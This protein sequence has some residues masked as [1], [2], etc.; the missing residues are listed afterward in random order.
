MGSS[1]LRQPGLRE[2][3]RRALQE[4]IARAAQKLFLLKGFEATTID[5][6]AA[7][8]G[9]SQRSFFR[10]FPTKEDI[11]LSKIDMM[12]SDMLDRLRNGPA[13]EPI[14]RSLRCIFD[15]VSENGEQAQVAEPIQRFVFTT[16]R[17]LAGYLQKLQKMQDE[18]VAILSEREAAIGRPFSV[19]D[20]APRALTS[21]AFGCLVAAQHSWLASGCSKPLGEFIDLAMATVAPTDRRFLP[22]G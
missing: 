13:E 17:L 15:A 20:P 9:M 10:Y 3:T 12:E 4:D 21:A 7:E 1:S 11:I 14:W 19:E 18:V 6:I 5:D 8:V 22:T 2:R 16:P